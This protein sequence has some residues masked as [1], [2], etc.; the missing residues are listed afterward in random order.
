VAKLKPATL[1]YA[2]PSRRSRRPFISGFQLLLGLCFWGAVFSGVATFVQMAH[3][4]TSPQYRQYL[5]NAQAQQRV[6]P[7]YVPP[8]Y[9]G[10]R[11]TPATIWDYGTTYG[12]L[13]SIG[14]GVAAIVG[15]LWWYRERAG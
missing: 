14:I 1:D 5:M 2:Q 8:P 4:P 6:Q 13:A 15:R 10:P 7:A 11:I 12:S 9:V 3:R